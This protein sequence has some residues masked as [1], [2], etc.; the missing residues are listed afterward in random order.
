MGALLFAGFR[1]VSGRRSCFDWKRRAA[2]LRERAVAGL[3]GIGSARGGCDDCAGRRPLGGSRLPARADHDGD[4]ACCSCSVSRSSGSAGRRWLG[5]RAWRDRARPRRGRRRRVTNMTRIYSLERDGSQ[6]GQPARFMVTYFIGGAAG[7]MLGAVGV[8]AWRSGREFAP[9][10]ITVSACRVG[11]ASRRTIARQD[12]ASFVMRAPRSQR[13]PSRA[14]RGTLEVDGRSTPRSLVALLLGMTVVGLVPRFEAGRTALSVVS[15]RH[16][17]R[18]PRH[19]CPLQPTPA[20][21]AIIPLTAERV[22]TPAPAKETDKPRRPNGAAPP[23][24]PPASTTAAGR[25][26]REIHQAFR[27][28]SSRC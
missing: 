17:R 16:A 13:C 3:F 1:R 20:A 26:S 23:G 14:K 4:P 22:R 25:R 2:A 10:G 9:F 5:P 7:S 15:F 27:A 28:A 11:S 8:G 24:C 18:R 21:D 19:A 12:V 6:P